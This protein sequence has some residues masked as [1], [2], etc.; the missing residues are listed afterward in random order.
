MNKGKELICPDCGKKFVFKESI[1][2][3]D[4]YY[5]GMNYR[6][7]A[8]VWNLF[9]LK[10]KLELTINDSYNSEYKKKLRS[11]QKEIEEIIIKLSDGNSQEAYDFYGINELPSLCSDC[12]KKK[13][14]KEISSIKR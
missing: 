1:K 7:F 3:A 5:K 4:L 10:K 9:Q 11:V 12:R 13:K 8:E 14:D 2:P 6:Y